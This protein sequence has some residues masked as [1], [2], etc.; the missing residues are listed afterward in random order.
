MAQP[1][2]LAAG[3]REPRLLRSDREV[4]RSHELATSRGGQAVHPCEDGLGMNCRVVISSAQ[5]AS[6]SR[7]AARSASTM[8]PK[9]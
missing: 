1:A 7:D 8:S 9:S 4:R 3:D 5:N 2:A 6:G